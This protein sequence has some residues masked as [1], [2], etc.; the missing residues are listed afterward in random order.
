MVVVGPALGVLGREPVVGLDDVQRELPPV[1]GPRREEGMR[2]GQRREELVRHGCC[3][4]AAAV[5]G[6]LLSA[7]AKLALWP[8]RRRFFPLAF[9]RVL[10][11]VRRG[12]RR[13][14]SE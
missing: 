14:L 6:L 12:R 13:A 2:E 8:L 1:V 9:S 4:R 7:T 3:R 5:D 10:V 11:G